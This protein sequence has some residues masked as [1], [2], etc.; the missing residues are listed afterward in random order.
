MTRPAPGQERGSSPI[1]GAHSV[2]VPDGGTTAVST[3]GALRAPTTRADGAARPAG[4]LGIHP[5]LMGPLLVLTIL[6]SPFGLLLFLLLRAMR[7]SR[8]S[9]ADRDQ[10]RSAS[11]VGSMPF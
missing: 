11:P 4:T 9:R 7:A 6:L 10:P 3:Y 5:L 2:G 8:A 1:V